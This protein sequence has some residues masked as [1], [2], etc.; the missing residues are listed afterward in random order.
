M[1][2]PTIATLLASAGQQLRADFEHVRA[3]MPHAGIKG[4][5]VEQILRTFLDRHLPQRFRTG[6]GLMIDSANNLSNEM[7][8]IVYDALSSP[9][10]RF[11]ERAQII[12]A[13]S[14]ASIVQVKSSLNKR[15]LDDAYKNIASAKKLKKR[16][17]SDIDR[18]AT[19]SPL[20]TVATF[21]V[22]FGFNADTS[23][24]TLA[25]NAAEL[26]TQFD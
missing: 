24:N 25:E 10:Y 6:T 23:L 19:G 17:L 8:I 21:G 2:K 18:R 1:E 15:E 14:V 3:T 22:V 26:N 5:E 4:A 16:P 11:S 7:D 13:D 12:P 9:L 20:S